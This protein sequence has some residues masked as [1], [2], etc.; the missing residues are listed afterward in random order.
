MLRTIENHVENIIEIQKSKFVCDLYYVDN[1]ADAKSILQNIR[2]KHPK[3]VHHCYAYVIKQ[4]FQNIENQSDDGE[5]SKTAG[6]PMLEILRYE[7][8]V[9]VLA[10]V[11]RYFG[12]TLL[13]TGGLIRAYS[14]SV[15]QA[16]DIASIKEAILMNGYKIKISYSTHQIIEHFLSTVDAKIESIEYLEDVEIIFYSDVENLDKQLINKTNNEIII[17]E[18]T[19]KY[20]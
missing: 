15:K 3:A 16:V 11:T 7:N 9:N 1:E 19:K 2:E 17:E 13:G 8:L 10:V 18:L 4:E 14:S 6:I 20:L 5:P 12:G